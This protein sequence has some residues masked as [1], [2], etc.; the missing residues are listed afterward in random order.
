M[1]FRADNLSRE[2]RQAIRLAGLATV[3]YWEPGPGKPVHDLQ[4]VTDAE[5]EMVVLI[6]YSKSQRK[7]VTINAFQLYEIGLYYQDAPMARIA[8]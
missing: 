2:A 4:D 1:M 7:S 5:L 8:R 3:A 6:A